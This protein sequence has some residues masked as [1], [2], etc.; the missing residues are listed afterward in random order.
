MRTKGM[1]I[2]V[3]VQNIAAAFNQFVNPIALAAITWKYYGV[4]L[5]IEV[6]YLIFI[7][8]FFPETKHK[9]I[10]E[11]SVIFDQYGKAPTKTSEL[12]QSA[13]EDV[14]S[15]EKENFEEV[16]RVEVSTDGKKD[17]V[18]RSV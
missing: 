12:Q 17:T 16:E 3:A 15:A 13:L 1:A 11:V 7:Y 2:F 9:T 14:Y 18:G 6:A 8:F 5:V 10:E 4:Y